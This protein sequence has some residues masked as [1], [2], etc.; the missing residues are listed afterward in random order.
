MSATDP[1]HFA[2]S[3]LADESRTAE[4]YRRLSRNYGPGLLGAKLRSLAEDEAAHAVFW[5]TFLGNRGIDA[6]QANFSGLKVVLFILV[7]RVFGVGFG[8]KLLEKG[9]HAAIAGYGSILTNESISQEERARI[10]EIL[11]DE[12]G[13]DD[14]FEEYG[15][16]YKF[17]IDRAAI[18][19]TQ[20]SGGLVTVLSVTAGLASVYSQPF[21]AGVAG[22]LVGL[23]QAANSAVSFYFFGKTDKQV[24][25]GILRRLK[26]PVDVLPGLFVNKLV[27]LLQKDNLSKHAS[28]A[29]GADAAKNRDLLRKLIAKQKYGIDED[30]LGTPVKNGLYAGLFRTL[31]TFLPLIPYL[32]NLPT[33]IALPLSVLITLAA[34]ALVGFLVAVAAET[35]VKLKIAELVVSGLVLTGL[36]LAIG[37]AASRVVELL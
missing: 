22:M 18:I 5:T 34:L 12:L 25:V 33:S 7:F 8:L 20:V 26:T 2:E 11:E 4:I 36:A 31:G 32:A 28:T 37:A 27:S 3:A 29:V 9:E 16:K 23:T 14:V 35:S 1:V 21:V 15:R 10:K 13:H 30:K 19:L 17:F 6:R 24:K